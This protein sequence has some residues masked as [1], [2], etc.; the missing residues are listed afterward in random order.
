M[1]ECRVLHARV[2][3][4][5]NSYFHFSL[6]FYRQPNDKDDE[7]PVSSSSSTN[8]AA[9]NTRHERDSFFGFVPQVGR[10]ACG[11]VSK[12]VSTAHHA[13]C[14]FPKWTLEFGKGTYSF[15]RENPRVLYKEII[16]GF[17]VAIMQV[18][19]SIAFSFVAGVPPLSGLQA[20]FWMALIT[21]VFGG[22]PGMISG[23]KNHRTRG[24]YSTAG[25]THSLF[26]LL[27]APLGPWPS[28]SPI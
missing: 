20:T 19:E 23:N 27:Q 5:Q 26:S 12:E 1:C 7:T 25:T 17:T 24:P 15:Y 22:K 11:I 3:F 21:G 9:A 2:S 14:G 13:V 28:L 4:C 8:H 18:P 6:H 10:W 16:S